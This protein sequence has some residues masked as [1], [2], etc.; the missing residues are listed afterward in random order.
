[1]RREHIGK[2]SMRTRKEVKRTGWR[3]GG[4]AMNRLLLLPSCR[5]S[6]SRSD[7]LPSVLRPATRSD[8]QL[9]GRPDGG[10]DVLQDARSL[11][12]DRQMKGCQATAGVTA[13]RSASSLAPLLCLI[14]AG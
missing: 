9:P 6:A 4:A 7:W 5:G 11:F 3:D 8:R 1:M 2:W 13:Y 10:T 14:M 12:Q